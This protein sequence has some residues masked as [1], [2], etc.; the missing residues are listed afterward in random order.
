MK[1]VVEREQTV[2]IIFT[3]PP[4]KNL[5]LLKVLKQNVFHLY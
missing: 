4:K 3:N 2:L 5:E 1:I